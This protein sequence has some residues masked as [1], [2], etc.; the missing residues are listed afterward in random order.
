MSEIVVDASAALGWVLT[1]QQTG[2]ARA[3]I[4][5]RRADRF[6]APHVFPWEI[7]NVLNRFQRRGLLTG[8]GYD[9]AIDDLK[10]LEIEVIAPQSVDEVFGLGRRAGPLGLR[11]FDMAYLALAVAR[12]CNLASRDAGLLGV[13]SRYVDCFDLRGD[14]LA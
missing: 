1:T 11:P 6:I 7:A 10:A 14:Q 5:Q 9:Q 8:D 12:G 4:V 3:F 2:A 13:A